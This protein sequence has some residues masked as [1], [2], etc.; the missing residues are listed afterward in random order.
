ML[1]ALLASTAM[2]AAGPLTIEVPDSGQIVRVG[3]FHP[4]QNLGRTHFP[5]GVAPIRRN[6]IKAFGKP[7]RKDRNGCANKWAAL[8]LR[9]ITADF[10]GGAPC[11]ATTP[12]QQLEVSSRSHWITE[13]GLQVGDSLDK[14]RRLYPELKRYSDLYG[15]NAAWRYD[16]ALVLEPSDVA[17]PPNVIDRLSAVIRGRKVK[18]LRVS[19]YGAGD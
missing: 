13:R 6:A 18:L 8:K 15:K 9:L 11:R 3:G 7:D 19:P 14:V 1:A 10:S 5:G 17:G 2:V 12:I 16:W 4:R